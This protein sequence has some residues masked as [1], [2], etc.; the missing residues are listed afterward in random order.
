M[1]IGLNFLSSLS[2]HQKNSQKGDIMIDFDVKRIKMNLLGTGLIKIPRSNRL[3][4]T[5]IEI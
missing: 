4:P 5:L 1:S 3:E 2:K